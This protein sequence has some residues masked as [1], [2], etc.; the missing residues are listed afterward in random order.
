MQNAKRRKLR[1]GRETLAKLGPAALGQVAG[2][3]PFTLNISCP[4]SH[5][6]FCEGGCTVETYYCSTWN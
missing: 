4:L 5:Y 1:L 2:G 3:A 6:S